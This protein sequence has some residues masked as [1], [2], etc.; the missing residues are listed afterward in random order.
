MINENLFCRRTETQ[1]VVALLHVESGEVVTRADIGINQAAP[2]RVTGDGTVVE[3]GLGCRYEHADGI[4]LR[5]SDAV[6]LG[7]SVEG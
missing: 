6:R 1:G 3:T 2:V 7:L 5:E 4:L